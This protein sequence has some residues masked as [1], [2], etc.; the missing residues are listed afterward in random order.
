[1]LCELSHGGCLWMLMVFHCGIVYEEKKDR[2]AT[3]VGERG[4]NQLMGCKNS[5]QPKQI[6][7]DTQKIG[8]YGL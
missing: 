8:S 2:R 1:M 4:Y 5:H 7:G 6:K 3:W